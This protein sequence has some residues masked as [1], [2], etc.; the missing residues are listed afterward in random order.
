MNQNEIKIEEIKVEEIK[1]EVKPKRKPGRPKKTEEENAARY[2]A[3][4]KKYQKERYKIDEE[5]R[6]TRK[7]ICANYREKKK[8][9]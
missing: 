2:L 6:T 5:Y 4:Q 7:Q 1:V 8:I 9:N 3:Y